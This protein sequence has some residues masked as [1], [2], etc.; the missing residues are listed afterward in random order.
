M[1]RSVIDY[2]PLSN[3]G[4]IG[5]LIDCFNPYRPKP[6]IIY[7]NANAILGYSCRSLFDTIMNY[8]KTFIFDQI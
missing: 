4:F 3:I 2:I 7:S 8:Y 1:I 6:Y 5:S